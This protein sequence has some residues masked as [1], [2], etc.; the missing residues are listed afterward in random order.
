MGLAGRPLIKGRVPSGRLAFVLVVILTFWAMAGTA[1]ALTRGEENTIRVFEE[2][3]AGVVNIT[4]IA[5]DRDFFF[6][7]VPTEGSGSGVI[8][9]DRGYIVTSFHV[10]GGKE[11]LEVTLGD[12]SKWKA[13]LVGSSVEN[14]LAV[15]KIDSPP[16]LLK[17]LSL[18]R[19][20]KVKV[21]Q[22]VLAVGNPFGLGHTLTTGTV[23]SVGRDIRINRRTV[24]RHVI[25]TD[26]AINPGNSGGPLINSDGEVIGI[27][28]AI[29]SPTGSS[30]GIGF[31]IPADTVR[32]LLPGL[33]SIW[34]RILSW[35]LAILLVALFIWWFWRKLERP[36]GEFEQFSDRKD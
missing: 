23:S 36:S 17:P 16:K 22:K 18:G 28:T 19:S 33:V 8:V 21:G 13:R 24:I 35:V 3:S 34:P 7:P 27:N 15:I 9:D 10:V 26:A 29:F 32:K 6:N 30:V 31:A 12:G 14:D 11:D 25:Q 5:I 1:A 4:T 2:V 20:S